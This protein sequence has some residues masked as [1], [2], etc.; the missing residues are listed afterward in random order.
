MICVTEFGKAGVFLS[1]PPLPYLLA[2]QERPFWTVSK[3]LLNFLQVFWV[4]LY[5]DMFWIESSCNLI[6][7]LKEISQIALF[8][9]LCSFLIQKGLYFQ[10]ERPNFISIGTEHLEP[11]RSWSLF[12][13]SSVF[14][15]DGRVSG[16]M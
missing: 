16:M 3:L 14:P 15:L 5:E 6:Y 2:A 11:E 7:Y 1:P 13:A 10:S 12:K 9:T 8:Q 4:H